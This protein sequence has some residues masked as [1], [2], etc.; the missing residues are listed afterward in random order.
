MPETK[1]NAGK[2]L[3]VVMST[4]GADT[5]IDLVVND[6]REDLTMNSIKESAA[7]VMPVLETGAGY[8]PVAV[9][10]AYYEVVTQ[11]SIN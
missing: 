1:K 8:T 3:H 7:K 10:K 2:T 4:T 5:T 9:T 11:T 6:P